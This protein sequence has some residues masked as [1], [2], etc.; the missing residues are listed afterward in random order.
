MTRNTTRLTVEKSRTILS[1]LT[2]VANDLVDVAAATPAPEGQPTDAGTAGP[3]EVV[4]ALEVVIDELEQVSEAIPAEPTNGG[5]EVPVEAGA[6]AP[7]AVAPVEESPVDSPA[8]EAPLDDDDDDEP[9]LAKQVKL[10]TAQLDKINR[11]KIATQYAELFEESK[12]QQAKFD[13]VITSK[14]SLNSWTAKISSI[15]QYKQH[16][17]A[18]SQ[19]P[20]KQV[21]FTSWVQPKSRFAKL[22]GSN[23]MLS[24]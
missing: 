22:Q 9:K 17:G 12:V 6:E 16:E 18:T 19:R 1:K 5:E 2:K 24:L 15:E 11:E 13:E 23:E 3:Q 14:E 21:N 4:D 7:V 8:E 20:A 10:L